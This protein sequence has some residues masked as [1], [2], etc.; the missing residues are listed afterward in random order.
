MKIYVVEKFCFF[1]MVAV[2][3]GG[4]SVFAAGCTEVGR[5]VA[6]QEKGVLVRSKPVIQD[7]K[8]MCMVVV[9]VPARDGEKLRRVEVFVSAD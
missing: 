8:D 4:N 2:L 3:L 6:T 1:V 5:N 7:G 9:I